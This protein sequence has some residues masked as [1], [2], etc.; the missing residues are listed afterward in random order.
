[1]SAFVDLVRFNPT[2]GGTTD[3]TVSTAVAGCQLPSSAGIVNTTSYKYYAVSGDLSQWEIGQGI[4]NTGTGV[5]PRT[6]VLY[7][8]SATGT[9]TGQSGAGTKIN[10]STVPQ[11]SIIAIAEDLIS[12]E[13]ANSFTTAQK[14]QARTNIGIA[15]S[16]AWTLINTLTASNSAT[17]TDTSSITGTYTEYEIVLESI[18]PASAANTLEF[19]VQVSSFQTGSY[20]SSNAFGN[21]S[22]T[23]SEALTTGILVGHAAAVGNSGSGVSGRYLLSNPAQ[24]SSPKTIYGNFIQYS[25]VVLISG[26]SGGQYNGGNGAVTGVQLLATTGNLTSGVMKIYGRN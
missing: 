6:T 9:A 18:I 23:G 19:Q 12:I 25:G 14:T 24:T 3:W 13:V 26:T 2:L 20:L 22:T 1:M 21:T 4:Y 5:L 16:G 10:F 15:S 8:S 7:N 17:L 11:V